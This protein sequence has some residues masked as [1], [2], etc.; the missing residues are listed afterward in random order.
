MKLARVIK[1]VY[2]CCWDFLCLPLSGR[3]SVSMLAVSYHWLLARARAPVSSCSLVGATAATSRLRNHSFYL[4]GPRPHWLYGQ[5]D[6]GAL[7]SGD[8]ACPRFS[9]LVLQAMLLC[10]AL[11]NFFALTQVRVEFLDDKDRTIV[12][13]VRGPVRHGDILTLLEWE[14]EVR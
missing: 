13:N 3:S 6:A 5:R 9:F 1:C 4:Q 14:R 7:N 10:T 8:C 2:A 12:R 11:P